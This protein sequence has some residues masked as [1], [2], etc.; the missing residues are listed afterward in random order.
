MAPAEALAYLRTYE[1]V[2]DDYARFQV[3]G[4]AEALQLVAAVR[5]LDEYLTEK[6]D[7]RNEQRDLSDALKYFFQ[8][9]I[10]VVYLSDGG[11][12]RLI[13]DLFG[14]KLVWLNRGLSLDKPKQR[15]EAL[16]LPLG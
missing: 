12:S 14:N 5:V 15:A 7:C 11:Y 2:K 1:S 6:T 9:D 3:L 4:Q 10:W 8:G 16:G 13:L